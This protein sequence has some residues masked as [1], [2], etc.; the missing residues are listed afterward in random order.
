MFPSFCWRVESRVQ[1]FWEPW[2]FCKTWALAEVSSARPADGSMPRCYTACY[3]FRRH[4]LRLGH[5]GACSHASRYFGAPV[6]ELECPE[7]HKRSCEGNSLGFVIDVAIVPSE[8]CWFMLVLQS[9]LPDANDE[10]KPQAP[11]FQMCSQTRSA[12]IGGSCRLGELGV[13][14]R[15]SVARPLAIAGA[16]PGCR[17][18]SGERLCGRSLEDRQRDCADPWP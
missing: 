7:L 10:F 17:R 15:S 9:E 6:G 3:L 2:H 13:A 14:L 8:E 11:G 1:C 4:C 16:W 18:G 5:S 12:F